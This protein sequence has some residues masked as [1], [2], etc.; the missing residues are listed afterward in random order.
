MLT[1]FW[2]RVLILLFVLLLAGIGVGRIVSTYDVF[3][4][5]TDESA[6]IGC[7][8]EWLTQES[9]TYGHPPL[10]P[11]AVALGPFLVGIR[12]TIQGKMW[13]AGEEILHAHGL[14]YRNLALARMGVIPFFLL[15]TTFVWIWSRKLFGNTGA[16]VAT[17]FFT[18]LPPVL[19]H[20]GLA[21]T[22]M[23][24]TATFLCAIYS[25]TLWLDRP[26]AAR[27]L[28]LGMASALAILSKASALLLL[29]VCCMALFIWRWIIEGYAKQPDQPGMRSRFIASGLCIIS[30]F[31]VIWAGNHFSVGYLTTEEDR[32]HE[33][34]DQFVGKE[35][36]LHD[37]AYAFAEAPIFPA[38]AFLKSN[39]MQ[40]TVHNVHG[41]TCY[42]F[43]E[44][45]QKGWWYYFPVA[46][47]VKTPLPFLILTVLGIVM[48][49]RQVRHKRNWRL[50][51]PA[52][53]AVSILLVY[54]PMNIN[55][56]VR[57]ILPIYPL[58]AIVAGFGAISFWNLERMKSFGRCLVIVLLAWQVT[59]SVLIHPDYLAYFN[60]LAGRN[61]ERILL[62][63]NLDWG[64][65]LQ[66]LSDKLNDLGVSDVA[67][68]YFGTAD[69]DRFG[70]PAMRPLVPYQPTTGWIAISI[71]HLKISDGFSW[72]EAHEPAALVGRSIR[73]YYIPETKDVE[74][75]EDKV[76]REG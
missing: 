6:H 26:T 61:P 16:L 56:G 35:G 9:Y 59:A 37:F 53:C 51:E 22:D 21:T 46:L 74:I 24:I 66:R 38:T 20:A 54:L 50:L 39:I 12:S 4:Q 25:F 36:A 68:K 60:G 2:H 63:S 62:D 47:A 23:T 58:L 52:I 64:Q 72:L 14:Y 42:L 73:L 5:T 75:P 33:K 32:P 28:V 31:L 71:W 7:G 65:D 1:S 40:V 8:M 55:I 76:L 29:P 17:A 44:V 11:V 13:Q 67:I 30:A 43:G 70:L 19:A 18:S 48:I 49:A 57:H 27:S 41:H 34:I 10:P 45:R 15:A 3:N 69:L